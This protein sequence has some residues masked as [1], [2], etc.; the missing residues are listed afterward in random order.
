MSY[1]AVFTSHCGLL[2]KLSYFDMELPLFNSLVRGEPLN[3]RLRY[4]P[5][6]LE[7]LSSGAHHILI[8]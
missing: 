2:A 7:T 6:K 8:Y 3:S 5:Q 1:L 4:W